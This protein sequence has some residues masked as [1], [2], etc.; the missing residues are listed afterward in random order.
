M[1]CTLGSKA[2]AASLSGREA[3]FFIAFLRADFRALLRRVR[4]FVCQ[5]L[6]RT[7]FDLFA[8]LILCQGAES[9]RR[10]PDFQSGA[11]PLS[12]PG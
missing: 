4:V 1:L 10:L 2:R 12:Y 7:D 9:N 3:N 11:L 5:I 6:F 8:N